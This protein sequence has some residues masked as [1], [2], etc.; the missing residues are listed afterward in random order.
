M[1]SISIS[2]RA[3][4]P[5]RTLQKAA[6]LV[7]GVACLV[8]TGAAH[9]QTRPALVRSVDEPARVPYGGTITPTCPF[10]NVCVAEFQ[11]VPAGK[12]LRVT[13][14]A[15]FIR[16]NTA[17]QPHLFAIHRNDTSGAGLIS[18]SLL[19]P[20]QAAYYGTVASANQAVDLIFEA[21]E[22]PILE[23]GV[24]AG[25]GGINGSA[26]RLTLTGY[27]VDVAP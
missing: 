19:P 5:L 18:L 15:A 14:I 3:H 13:A 21:G 7:A 27:L 26:A 10:A 2:S 6:V 24:A 25:S 12:R 1:R 9:A 11:P 20:Q 23:I 8:V 22:R 4:R 16:S 17:S